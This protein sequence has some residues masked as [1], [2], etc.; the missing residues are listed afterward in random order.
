[1][2]VV[3]LVAVEVRGRERRSSAQAACKRG[4]GLRPVT[5]MVAWT[6]WGLAVHCQLPMQVGKAAAWPVT[7][8][9]R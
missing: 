8:G 2:A 9:G 4:K 1:M 5:M 7:G 6:S 3:A